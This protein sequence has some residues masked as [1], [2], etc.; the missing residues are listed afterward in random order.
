MITKKICFVGL[1]NEHNM[2]DPVIA[3]CTE[4]LFTN[5]SDDYVISHIVLDDPERIIKYSLFYRIK[6]RLRRFFKGSYSH[7]EYVDKVYSFAVDYYRRKVKR[8]N[9]VVLVGGGLIKYK[10][11]LL[12]VETAAL[13]KACELAGVPLIINAVGIEGYDGDNVI[14][15]LIEKSLCLS[16]LKYISTRDDID[17]LKKDYLKCSLEVKCEKVADPAVWADEVYKIIKDKSSRCIG[18]GIAR[19]G[20][21]KDNG[22]DLDGETLL[23]LYKFV[24]FELVKRGHEVNLFTNGL[25]ADNQMAYNLQNSLR[26]SGLDIPLHIPYK[27]VELVKILSMFRG[28]IATRLHSCIISYSLNIPAVGLVW[29]DKLSY[30]GNNIGSPENFIE[31]CDFDAQIIVNQLEKAIESGYNQEI[32]ESYRSTI[33]KSVSYVKKILT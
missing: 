20:L 33:K 15:K 2:G 25:F 27:D 28:V 29:N 18:I 14:C 12:G 32:R 13:C 26:L 9:I 19:D 8:K 5:G 6:S 21:F 4:W 10:Y 3:H 16:S 1:Y 23:N 30:F 11:Q 31:P 7:K 17:T 24:V 22:I